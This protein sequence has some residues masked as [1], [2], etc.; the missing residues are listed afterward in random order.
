MKNTLGLVLLSLSLLSCAGHADQGKKKG[1]PCN[2]IVSACEQA[3]FKKGAHQEKKGVWF[4]CVQPIMAGETVAGVTLT[5]D[6][7]AACEA[8]VPDFGQGKKKQE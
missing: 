7:V 4:D 6:D 3:G 5:A 1:G 2:R 8:K